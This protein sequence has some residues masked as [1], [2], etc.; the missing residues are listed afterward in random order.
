[1]WYNTEE[2]NEELITGMLL[3][4]MR[5]EHAGCVMMEIPAFLR[6][7]QH[8][9]HHWGPGALGRPSGPSLVLLFASFFIGRIL[10]NS[11]GIQE[12]CFHIA[13]SLALTTAPLLSPARFPRGSCS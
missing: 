1:M 12:T 2:V 10:L 9:A 4:A 13:R 11:T 7:L 8:V 5:S 3:S 6:A